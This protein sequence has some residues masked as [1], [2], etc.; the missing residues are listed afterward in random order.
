MAKGTCQLVT[1]DEPPHELPLPPA[2]GLFRPLLEDLR[3]GA[4]AWVEQET[5]AFLLT[6]AVLRARDAATEG[7]IL[8][9]RD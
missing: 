8:S 1:D 5:K 6:R 2:P 7:R 3:P 9:L 4:A